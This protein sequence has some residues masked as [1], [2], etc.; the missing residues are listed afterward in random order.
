MFGGKTRVLEELTLLLIVF[1]HRLLLL[2]VRVALGLQLGLQLRPL[3]FFDCFLLIPSRLLGLART[4]WG[5]G[6]LSL[7]RY[8]PSGTQHE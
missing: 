2:L 1:L 4:F 3:V 5:T 6:V 7:G 8:Q